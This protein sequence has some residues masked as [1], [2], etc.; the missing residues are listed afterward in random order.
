MNVDKVYQQL[1]ANELVPAEW[2]PDGVEVV[3][4]S[5][6]TGEGIEELIRNVAT[7][8]RFA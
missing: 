4:T 1:A 6:M 7:H 8:R 3:K 5:A 2:S